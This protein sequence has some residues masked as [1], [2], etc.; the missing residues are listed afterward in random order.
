MNV[1]VGESCSNYLG[2]ANEVLAILV[3]RALSTGRFSEYSLKAC[4]D[5]T[6]RLMVKITCPD[7]AG[8]LSFSESSARYSVV[9]RKTRTIGYANLVSS[10][11]L[12]DGI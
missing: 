9:R 3:E 7:S 4:V 11:L 6:A 8:L 1:I 5:K 12:W 2:T 10:R